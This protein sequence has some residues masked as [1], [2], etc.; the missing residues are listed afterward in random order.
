MLLLVSV[1]KSFALGLLRSQ[2]IRVLVPCHKSRLP[3]Q[4]AVNTQQPAASRNPGS[5]QPP[6]REAATSIRSC[7]EAEQE[8]VAEG[9]YAAQLHPNQPD[10]VWLHT[11]PHTLTEAV[12]MPACHLMLVLSTVLQAL[13][14]KKTNVAFGC[15]STPTVSHRF[16]HQQTQLVTNN[17][18]PPIL[19]LICV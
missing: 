10:M 11:I 17:K 2:M 19:P 5:P 8:A 6:V 7:G 18:I 3:I 16:V 4:R 14:M 15:L 9:A 1:L 13:F 12:T